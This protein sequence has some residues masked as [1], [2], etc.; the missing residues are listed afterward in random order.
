MTALIEFISY[1]LIL[2]KPADEHL[3]AHIRKFD[4]RSKVCH[5]FGKLNHKK[6]KKPSR[7]WRRK[8][9]A[10]L[11]RMRGKYLRKQLS[12]NDISGGYRSDYLINGHRTTCSNTF[13]I[14]H[15]LVLSLMS[16]SICMGRG[17]TFYK[18]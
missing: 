13:N 3:L 6:F 17:K 8:S 5:C 18:L 16:Y 4:N 10:E 12:L 11:S 2:I 14:L 7:D 1:L 9:Q 15:F